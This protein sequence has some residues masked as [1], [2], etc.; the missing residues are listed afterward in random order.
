MRATLGSLSTALL[1]VVAAS[2]AS[3]Q[4][5][6]PAPEPTPQPTLSTAQTQ[7]PAL[8]AVPS[9][10]EIA[11]PPPTI[12]PLLDFSES[13]VK[14]SLTDL[15]RVLR[16][17]RHEGWVL[18]AYP[19]PKTG[20]PLIGAGFSLDLPERE[21]PQ[22]DPLNP[23]VFVEPSSAELWQAAGLAPAHLQQVL[24]QFN[25]KLA[26]WKT[27]RRYRRRFWSLDPQITDDEAISLLRIAA[28][29]SIEN[30]RAY[31]RNF[32]QLSGPQQMALS[33]LVY[34]M[35]V[36]LEEFGNFLSLINNDPVAVSPLNTP[37]D[38]P[39]AGTNDNY[40][41]AVQHSLM[42]SQW[43]RLYRARAVAVIAMLD[44]QYPDNPAAS[45]H[46]IAAVL[47]PAVAHRR[48]SRT[49]LRSA[50]FRHHPGSTAPRKS[51]RARS[52]RKV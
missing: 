29:Q 22:R 28:I 52:K 15:M 24:E 50:A 27:A 21:H 40:W 34:Q 1:V 35:G 26:T 41:Q 43:A 32:D 23:H 5:S 3:A 4:S 37:I 18:A 10:S 30:A 7:P 12:Q 20:R 46:R 13:E 25:D 16:D 36:N 19:D 48:R 42:Q 11:V 49:A 31:C 6:S 45:E 14:F 38:S 2:W 39:V 9:N 8:P 51:T 33:Q 17:H 44:P 47:R